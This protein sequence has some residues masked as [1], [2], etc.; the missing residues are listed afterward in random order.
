[1]VAENVKD[2]LENGN[3][4]HSVNFPETLLPRERAHRVAIPH[5]NKP[6]MVAQIL[7]AFGDQDLNIAD[8]INNSRGDISYT[9][10]DLDG[11]VSAETVERIKAIDGILSVR[12]LPNPS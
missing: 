9:L 3:I 5:A 10:V 2:Y 11:A 4:K 8:M 1:M 6:N 12:I 7:T